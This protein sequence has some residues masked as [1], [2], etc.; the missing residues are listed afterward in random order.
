M[1]R[2][3]ALVAALT[4]AGCATAPPIVTTQ[5][6]EVPVP[7]PCQVQP[8][9]PPMWALDTL[10]ANASMYERVRAM[11]AEITQRQAYELRLEAAAK[12]CE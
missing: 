1:N 4:L 5:R 6:V 10:P 12:S 2:F 8:I 9:K 7:V 11:A 3:A